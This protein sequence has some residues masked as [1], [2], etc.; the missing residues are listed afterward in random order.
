[1][2]VRRSVAKNRYTSKET[3]QQLLFDK[4]KNVAFVASQNKNCDTKRVLETDTK[5]PCVICDKDEVEMLNVC[6]DCVTLKNYS[7]KNSDL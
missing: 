5:H 2:L 1:M 4:V 7:I 6:K 3:L